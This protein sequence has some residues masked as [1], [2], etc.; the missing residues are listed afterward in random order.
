VAVEG[1]Q[2]ARRSTGPGTQAIQLLNL[3]LDGLENR[4]GDLRR[5]PVLALRSNLVCQRLQRISSVQQGRTIDGSG[6]R[7]GMQR[8][9]GFGNGGQV[10]M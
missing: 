9:Q 4:R 8:G 2:A 1:D 10:V 5:L 6:Q 3:L 7:Q